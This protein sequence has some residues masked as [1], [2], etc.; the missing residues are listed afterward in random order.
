[1]L[2]RRRS[3]T[4]SH[5]NERLNIIPSKMFAQLLLGTTNATQPNKKSL[6]KEKD[7]G[8]PEW[9]RSSKCGGPS[10]PEAKQRLSALAIA[11]RRK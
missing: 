4:V 5:C 2:S 8:N 11:H 6:G 1:M 10:D 9:Q 3:S 7:D